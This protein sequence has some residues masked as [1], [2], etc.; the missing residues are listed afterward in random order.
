MGRGEPD[1]FRFGGFEL[2]TRAVELR[3]RGESLRIFPRAFDL[4]LYLVRAARA[5]RAARGVAR[6]AVARRDG[7]QCGAD[8]DRLGAAQ[9]AERGR[10]ASAELI[11][12]A[13]GAAIASSASWMPVRRGG[14][15]R[16]RHGA[17]RRRALDECARR[18]RSRPRRSRTSGAR[19][20]SQ[21]LSVALDA[22]CDGRGAAYLLGGEPGIGKT[23]AAEE[24]MALARER[25]A[26]VFDG[27]C[28]ESEGGPPFWPWLQLVRRI[29]ERERAR[30]AARVHGHRR[31]RSVPLLPRA[32]RDHAGRAGAAGAAGR[33]RSLLPARQRGELPGARVAARVRSLFLLDDLQWA[34]R[35]R[36]CCSRCWRAWLPRAR[37]LVIGT[38]RTTELSDPQPF[39]RSLA[40]LRAA[41]SASRSPV[42]PRPTSRACSPARSR[43]STPSSRNRCTRSPA[44]IRC[45]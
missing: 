44:A 2:D 36:C 12:N 14:R 43:R 26:A 38:Y 17:R 22:A 10:D 7:H 24:I 21:R 33:A 34:D 27:R 31:A 20:R 1:V 37:M 28:Y 42:C 30:G 41:A 25:G 8:A 19:P 45:S 4:L 3:R 39:A 15:A 32:A 18:Q 11:R 23:R 6:G 40:A 16:E 35:A 9:G 13:R 29:V 5:R